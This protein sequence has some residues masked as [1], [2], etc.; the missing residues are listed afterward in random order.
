MGLE[1]VSRYTRGNFHVR[2]FA[3]N[4]RMDHCAQIGLYRDVLKVHIQPRWR[5]PRGRRGPTVASS[6]VAAH[7]TAAPH[8]ARVHRPTPPKPPAVPAPEPKA[9]QSESST[10]ESASASAAA[11]ARLV[12][13]VD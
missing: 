8:G 12:P 2:G 11:E 13:L 10:P 3:G 5:S 6:R 1:S 7:G 9:A 4:G